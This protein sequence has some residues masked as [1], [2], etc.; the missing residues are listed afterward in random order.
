M[1]QLLSKPQTA[2]TTG[3]HTKYVAVA[4]VIHD[5]WP[6]AET[7]WPCIA[8]IKMAEADAAE[9]ASL[10]SGGGR[11]KKSPSAKTSKP[12]KGK[13]GGKDGGSGAGK[14]TG[15]GIQ[16]STSLSN[17]DSNKPHW[18]LRVALR[19]SV[20]IGECTYIQWNYVY[21]YIMQGNMTLFLNALACCVQ[22]L[23]YNIHIHFNTH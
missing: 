1:C 4:R 6:L 19:Q 13:G 21:V 18:T 8:D 7:A 14:E 3:T 9:K 12:K 16:S 10:A 17:I 15:E 22:P 23:L 5:S 11:G 2:E 20:S